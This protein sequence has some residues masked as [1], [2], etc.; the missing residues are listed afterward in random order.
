LFSIEKS[1]TCIESVTICTPPHHPIGKISA[2]DAGSPLRAAIMLNK[3]L[4]TNFPEVELSE[5]NKLKMFRKTISYMP[6][7]NWNIG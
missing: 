5:E 6:Q 3:E 1:L 7:N 4:G 2:I